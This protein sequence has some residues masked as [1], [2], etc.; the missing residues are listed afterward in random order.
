[1]PQQDLEKLLGGYATNTLTDLERKA[2]FDAALTNQALFNAL[3]DEQALKELL[4]DPRSRRH[5]LEALGAIDA[6]ERHRSWAREIL[7]WVQRPSSW[8]LAGSVAVAVLAV[9]L[10]LREGGPPALQPD[11]K[12]ASKPPA[13]S[14]PA[15]APLPKTE[16]PSPK[17]NLEA[18]AGDRLQSINRA[19]VPASPLQEAPESKADR[20]P[21]EEDA[22]RMA[23]RPSP[24]PPQGESAAGA[25]ELLKE[26]PLA[27]GF[28]APQPEKGRARELFY[29]TPLVGKSAEKD[30]VAQDEPTRATKPGGSPPV[31]PL[32]LRYSILR[33]G[34]E[35]KAGE[36]ARLSVEANDTGYLYVLGQDAGGAW[37]VL[38]PAK[39]AG[40]E[41]ARVEKRRRYTI[42]PT[43]AFTIAGPSGAQ[44]LLI[45]F[46][47]QPRADL[48]GAPESG[49]FAD[50]HSDKK[51]APIDDLA[52]R[53]RKQAGTHAP[54]TEEVEEPTSTGGSEKAVYVVDPHSDPASRLMVEITFP[55]R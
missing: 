9:T 19:K 34:A 6:K 26:Q 47:R 43:G 27:Q 14:E 49:L 45:V 30:R 5:L 21:I 17:K 25:P 7:T 12:T 38:F 20:P 24:S 35:E 50:L 29:G 40:A 51:K 37:T 48:R 41:A 28:S 46:S 39:E 22:G 44:R 33:G 4:D 11:Q 42:P 1:M 2:L 3:A 52:G 32:G 54:L 23:R 18:P 31:T 13:A 36:S 15:P 55:P 53:A 10:V 8:A 16:S